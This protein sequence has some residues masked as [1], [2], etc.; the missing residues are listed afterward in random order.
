MERVIASFSR[1]QNVYQA[2]ATTVEKKCIGHVQKR[3]DPA[4]R[5]LKH[6][7]PGLEGKG[8]NLIEQL[9]SFTTIME[10]LFGQMWGYW[11]V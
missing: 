10:L 6:E 11:Q 1:L 4:L 9:T 7:N 3:V 2:S 8:N 5:K